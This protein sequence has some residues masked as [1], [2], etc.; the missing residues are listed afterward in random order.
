MIFFPVSFCDFLAGKSI[1]KST[2]NLSV[3]NNQMQ[4]VKMVVLQLIRADD[5]MKLTHSQR[6][7]MFYYRC[8]GVVNRVLLPRNHLFVI[9][10]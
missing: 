1:L 2:R 9:S 7:S 4:S 5:N 3:F 10:H 8:Q 6:Y